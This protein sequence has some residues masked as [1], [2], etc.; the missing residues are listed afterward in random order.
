MG[1]P[2]VDALVV[3]AVKDQLRGSQCTGTLQLEKGE[4]VRGIGTPDSDSNM[5][6]AAAGSVTSTLPTV[7]CISHAPGGREERLEGDQV[8]HDAKCRLV[9]GRT[10]KSRFFF[11]SF[12][13]YMD[14]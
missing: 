12:P 13:I 10:L 14:M 7:S 11:I 9:K 1:R 8:Q 6:S 2:L 3:V 4:S 5:W